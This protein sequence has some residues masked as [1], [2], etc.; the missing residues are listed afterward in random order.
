MGLNVVPSSFGWELVEWKPFVHQS[1]AEI[2]G[3]P[4]EVFG[5]LHD[6]LG[7]RDD[8]STEGKIDLNL[9]TGAEPVHEFEGSGSESLPVFEDHPGHSFE[10]VGEVVLDEEPQTPAEHVPSILTDETL[11][12]E[13]TRKK[14]IKTLAGH[15]D[16][17]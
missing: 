14:R 7:I 16:L 17:Q 9:G 11:T 15:T 3:K 6:V 13:G 5:E 8:T 4:A 2:R 12:R 1:R 10:K